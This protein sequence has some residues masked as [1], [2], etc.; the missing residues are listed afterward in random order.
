MF[1]FIDTLSIRHTG[2]QASDRGEAGW[3]EVRIEEIGV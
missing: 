3:S 2:R 1:V